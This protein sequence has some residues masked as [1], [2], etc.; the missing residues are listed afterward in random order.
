M[1]RIS[2]TLRHSTYVLV[3]A[4]VVAALTSCSVSVSSP[5]TSTEADRVAQTFAKMSV[6]VAHKDG[7]TSVWS[8]PKLAGR[9][10]LPDGQKVS[11]WV[12]GDVSKGVP[13]RGYYLD[14]IRNKPKGTSGMSSWGQETQKVSLESGM[15]PIVVGDV[16]SWPA[17]T[18][19]VFVGGSSVDLRVIEDFF[20]VPGDRTA[21]ISKRFTITLLDATGTPL[22]TVSDLLASG[23]GTPH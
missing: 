10:S 11:L 22:G 5:P 9:T 20:L 23:S 7:F 3:V 21:D 12:A 4:S 16:G 14:F 17:K 8:T 15:P 19:R 13:T 6:D 1:S 18:V 2:S